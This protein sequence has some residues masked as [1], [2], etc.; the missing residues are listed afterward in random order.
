MRPIRNDFFPIANV[1]FFFPEARRRSEPA[2]E[3]PQVFRQQLIPPA[4]VTITSREELEEH[5]ARVIMRASFHDPAN[6]GLIQKW[7]DRE[8]NESSPDQEILVRNLIETD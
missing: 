8:T 6:G 7:I 4:R 3:A 2:P 5:R 1:P